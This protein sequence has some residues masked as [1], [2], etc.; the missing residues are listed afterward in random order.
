MQLSG[1]ATAR[2]NYEQFLAEHSDV[3]QPE[4]IATIQEIQQ[5]EANHMLKLQA[6]V[7]KYDG[8]LA[9]S[10]DDANKAIAAISEGVVAGAGIEQPTLE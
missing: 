4:D 5:D 2:Q 3:L 8:N 9:A 10:P 7:R 1:E 6:M